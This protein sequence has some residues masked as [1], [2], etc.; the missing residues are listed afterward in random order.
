VVWAA[1]KGVHGESDTDTDRGE[2]RLL[3]LQ[4]CEKSVTG[5]SQGCHKGLQ[6]H[7]KGI[8]RALQEYHKEVLPLRRPTNDG[9][10]Y[11]FG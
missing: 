8:T 2:G 10:G 6:E 11:H 1:R 9:G 4:G 7:H 5:V 3:L